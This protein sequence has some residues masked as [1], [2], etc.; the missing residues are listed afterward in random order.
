MTFAE[1]IRDGFRLINR[2][3]QLVLIQIS[4]V[5]IS[6]IG[7]FIIVGLPLAIAFIIFGIDLTGLAD[8]RD[9]L[10]ML[11]GPSDILS[12]Y[13]GL[14]LIILTSILLYLLLVALLGV[15]IFGG[16]IGIIGR[17][18]RDS[19]SEFHMGVFFGEAKRLF[20]RL[21]G[22]TSVIGVIFIITFF[23]LGILGG[24]IAALVSSAQ[25][26]DSTLALFF[27]TFFS[28]ILFV[29]AFFVILGILSVALYGMASLFFKDTG[30]AKSVR[31][32]TRYLIRNPNAFWLYTVLFLGYLVA[33][34][35]L[36][37]LSYPFTLIPVIGTIL[38]FPYQL[39]SYT[40]QT[41]L[42]LMII[43]A[44]FAYYYST[45]FP[46]APASGAEPYV[47]GPA[48]SES[49]QQGAKAQESDTGSAVQD[50]L[51][52]PSE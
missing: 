37:L 16:S 44:I 7:A 28:M 26:Q 25:T 47:E 20:L 48:S 45:E 33:F 42:G 43:A 24:G 21:L 4:M 11:R 6:A 13:L 36:I 9:V 2:N 40:F 38:S 19:S 15:Y 27:G 10:G 41:Y 31:E 23:F 12:K 29:L 46:P 49:S 14:V 51:S 18:L 34:F 50:T 30:P 8:I 22:F 17:S 1:A 35:L 39:I 52:Q 3:W 5:F 32:A